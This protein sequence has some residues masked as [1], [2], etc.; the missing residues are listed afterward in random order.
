MDIG[1][2]RRFGW[3]LVLLAG[4]VIWELRKPEDEREWH[5]TIAGVMPYELRPPSLDRIRRTIWDPERESLFGPTVFGVGWSV[6]LG[7]LARMVGLA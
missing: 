2:P 6:N 3:F 4:L 7:R 5:G 1:R